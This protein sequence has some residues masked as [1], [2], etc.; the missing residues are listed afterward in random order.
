VAKWLEDN[1]GVWC[2]IHCVRIQVIQTGASKG[3]IMF[4]ERI[5]DKCAHL[6]GT[7]TKILSVFQ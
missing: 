2:H 3:N 6:K 1:I 4:K 7:A 5:N